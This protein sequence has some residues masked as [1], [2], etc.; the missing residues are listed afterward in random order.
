MEEGQKKLRRLMALVA[1]KLF[2]LT[3]ES[4]K[5]HNGAESFMEYNEFIYQISSNCFLSW[6]IFSLEYLCIKNCIYE[7]LKSFRK[8]WKSQ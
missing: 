1:L 7:T 4:L 6:I 5:I 2:S 3:F 8:L